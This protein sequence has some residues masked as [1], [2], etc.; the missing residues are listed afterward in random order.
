MYD[1]ARDAAPVDGCQRVGYV[2]PLTTFQTLREALSLRLAPFASMTP[3][4]L[5]HA[6]RG[7]ARS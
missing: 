5:R 4:E 7:R 1:S 6:K 3:G 2:V